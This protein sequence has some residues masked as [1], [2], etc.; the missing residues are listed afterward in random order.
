MLV[1]AR[2]QRSKG[3]ASEIKSRKND[4]RLILNQV[5]DVVMIIFDF[6]N[7]LPVEICT[8]MKPVV[9]C[10]DWNVIPDTEI[11]RENRYVEILPRIACLFFKLVSNQRLDLLVLDLV[12]WNHLKFEENGQV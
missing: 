4:A 7:D 8:E 6:F 3:K 12:S 2:K 11:E 9:V 5:A 1:T 10:A